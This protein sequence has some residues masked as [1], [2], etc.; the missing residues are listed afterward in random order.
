MKGSRDAKDRTSEFFA[1]VKRARATLPKKP[2]PKPPSKADVV[3]KATDKHAKVIQAAG[4]ISGKL[5]QTT[6][7][8]EE[9]AKLARDT[10]IFNDPREQIQRLTFEIKGEIDKLNSDLQTLQEYVLHNIKSQQHSGRQANNVVKQLKLQLCKTTLHFKD[11]LQVSSF[12]MR[13]QMDRRG[14]YQS[15]N[16]SRRS[17]RKRLSYYNPNDQDDEKAPLIE[18]IGGSTNTQMQALETKDVYYDL[19]NEAVQNI[20]KTIAQLGDMYTQLADIVSI[21]EEQVLR[22]DGNVTTTLTNVQLGNEQ[23]ENYWKNISGNRWLII[24]VFMV[25][26]FFAMFFSIFVA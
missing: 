12:S 18:E 4:E 14:R 11:V 16:N 20:E 21:Q 6:Q 19:R 7:R 23:L 25:L 17:R 2:R 8:L 15:Q 1:A 5:N 9:L 22:I 13:K 24:K 3:K 10:S 26:I